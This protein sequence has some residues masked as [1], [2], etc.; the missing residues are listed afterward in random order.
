MLEEHE[1]AVVP[2]VVG[3]NAA[4]R[5]REYNASREVILSRASSL[6]QHLM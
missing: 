5:R 6:T 2:S 1:M 3:Q 4:L